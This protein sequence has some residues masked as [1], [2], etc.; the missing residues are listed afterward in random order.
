MTVFAPVVGSIALVFG[1]LLW[2]LQLVLIVHVF[3]TG[4]PYWWFFVLIMA[5]GI[6][7]IAYLI[8][9][10][11]PEARAAGGGISWSKLK[12]RSMRIAELRKELEETDVVD[13]RLELAAELLADG[14][15]A[16]AH[17]VAVET[18]RGVFRD[19]PH[20]QT[21]AARYMIEAQHWNEALELIELIDAGDNKIL[22]LEVT[23]LRGRALQGTNRLEEAEEAFR[24]LDGHYIGEEPR[25][26]LAVV[27]AA[28]NRKAEAVALWKEIAT[29]YRKAS[30]LW[31][32]SEKRWY[33]LTKARLKEHGG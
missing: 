18:L 22:N 5:P 6:G 28:S 21:A 30:P 26:C 23:L 20:T 1:P 31:R 27:L 3:K 33:R 9:E 16:E 7:A 19:D 13:T 15:A 24:A 32:K 14:K 12:P 29:R 4:R 10:I 17:D 11:L 25:F 2:I 8:V